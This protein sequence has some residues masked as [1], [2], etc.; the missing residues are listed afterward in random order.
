MI[1]FLQQ[2]V[3]ENQ[4]GHCRD[5]A[6]Q[7]GVFKNLSG[8]AIAAP[9]AQ[10]KPARPGKKLKSPRPADAACGRCRFFPCKK[11]RTTSDTRRI[12][13]TNKSDLK[14][15][16]EKKAPKTKRPLKQEQERGKAGQGDI[17]QRG[18][19]AQDKGGQQQS[20][21]QE[22][23][24]GLLGGKEQCPAQEQGKFNFLESRAAWQ[25]LLE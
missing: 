4:R 21:A 18:G 7:D 3:E 12:S 23:Q 15:W 2:G 9:Q 19:L 6:L 8:R 11:G 22:I 17:F 10:K 16:G 1:V 24:I 25:N 13:P 20:E 14:G 5:D